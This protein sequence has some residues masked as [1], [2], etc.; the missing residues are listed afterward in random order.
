MPGSWLYNGGE[1]EGEDDGRSGG[2]RV[3]TEE[4]IHKVEKEL[5]G[6]AR[7]I[8]E[9]WEERQQQTSLE[10]A[11]Y[12]AFAG[13]FDW[14]RDKG[15]VETDGASTA[16]CVETTQKLMV[17]LNQVVEELPD[18][19][20]EKFRDIDLMLEG[21][22]TY[23]KYRTK[24]RASMDIADHVIYKNW[25]KEF[26]GLSESHTVFSKLFQNLQIRTASEVFIICF[27][28]YLSLVILSFIENDLFV[29]LSKI[30]MISIN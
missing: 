6:L 9:E 2:I 1:E 13:D 30:K 28:F 10:K 21:Y 8:M 16:V 19:Q 20:A 11:A 23:M 25:F 22:S 27:I 18:T 5:E 17:L 12:T 15:S 29:D 24:E 3:L 7:D 14:G 4:D 26:S